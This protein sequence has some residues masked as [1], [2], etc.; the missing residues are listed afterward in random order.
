MR[1]PSVHSMSTAHTSARAQRAPQ[2]DPQHDDPV[3]AVPAHR[4][5]DGGKGAGRLVLLGLAARRRPRALLLPLLRAASWLLRAA[6]HR[7]RTLLL[8]LLLLLLRVGAGACWRLAAAAG[9]GSLSA[10]RLALA[11]RLRLLSLQLLLQLALLRAAG[12]AACVQALQQGRRA[13]AGRRP[14]AGCRIWQRRGSSKSKPHLAQAHVPRAV[15]G[16]PHK[17]TFHNNKQPAESTL[18]TDLTQAHVARAVGGQLDERQELGLAQPADAQPWLQLL[19]HLSV[20]RWREGGGGG[21]EGAGGVADGG[22]AAC[23]AG[24]QQLQWLSAVPCPCSAS[25]ANP[26]GGRKPGATVS[27]GARSQADLAHQDV[28]RLLQEALHEVVETDEQ[29]GPQARARALGAADDAPRGAAR[30]GAARRRILALR[31]RRGEAGVAGGGGS[32]K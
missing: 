28:V 30:H 14:A 29:L 15:G 23:G 5:A 7:P 12:Q 21:R 32:A 10:R 8:L 24:R 2:H 18:L 17:S 16:Q 11:R 3:E 20:G 19:E 25:P 1:D 27:W 26:S 6:A 9:G 13:A 4:G 22:E 31:G